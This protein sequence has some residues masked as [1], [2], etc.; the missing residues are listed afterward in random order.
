M[1]E[2]DFKGELLR[3]LGVVISRGSADGILLS[4]GVDSSLL[5]ALSSRLGPIAGV[6]SVFEGAPASDAY[7]SSLVVERLRM[8]HVLT[9]Y[10]LQDAVLAAREV[11]KITKSF[12]HIAL[13]ND[14]SIYLALRACAE[15]GVN[16]V[17]TGDGG[18]E[19]FA[20]YEYMTKMGEDELSAYIDFLSK[21]W[22][23]ST[24]QLARSLGLEV[25]QPYLSEEVIDFARRLP[26]PW[27]VRK[28]DGICG[29]WILRSMLEDLGLPEIARR[30]KEPIESGSGSFSLSK[31]FLEG[32]GEEAE[33]L[34]A[35]AMEEGVTFWSDEQLY[36]YKIFRETV[37]RVPKAKEGERGCRCCGA[38]LD[39]RGNR[40][41]ICGFLNGGPKEL[42][43]GSGCEGKMHAR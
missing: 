5:A 29:K 36:F 13:R 21:N 16:R 28:S 39:P 20:G 22:T 18:D 1:S 15:G 12:D 10:G 41:T 31:I 43:G 25:I 42:E 7:Y 19:L 37:G 33:E 17:M 38:P 3:L 9:R 24:P 35:K 30:E 27:R 23:F 14:I 34:K 40:C 6:T 26:Y 32:L 8:R 11:V 2:V 4:G